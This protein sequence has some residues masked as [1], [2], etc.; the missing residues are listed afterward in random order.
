MQHGPHDLRISGRKG[1][2]RAVGAI[3]AGLALAACDSLLEVSLPGQTPAAALDD[4]AYASLLVLSAQGDFECAYAN[5]AFQ[6]GHLSG[7]L[8]GAQSSLNVTPIQ[9][10]TI[11]SIDGPWGESGCGSNFALYTPLSTARFMADDALRR[12][13]A[14]TDAEVPNRARLLGRASLYAGFS[15]GVFGESFCRATF[16]MGPEMAPREVLQLAAERFSAAIDFATQAGDDETLRAAYVGR[17]RVRLQ[18]GEGAA[19]AADARM[20]PAGFRFEV[21]RSNTHA[22][23]RNTIYVSNNQTRAHSVD[24]HFW[25]VTWQDTPDPR[26]RVTNTGQKGVDGL[27]DL[28]LQTKFTAEASPI[29]LASHT[30]AILIIAEVEGGETAVGII[31]EL[32]QAAGIPPFSSD[33]PGEILQM[34]REE[35][36]R[37]FFLEGRRMADLRRYGGNAFAEA[38]HGVHPFTG[39]I[40]GGTE[41]FPL[42][43]VELRNNPNVS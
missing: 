33:D 29:R 24:P 8:I 21:T 30:E 25:D 43:D 32:H 19:A 13:T 5:Y 6:A 36:R 1:R 37:E 26:V 18:L 3:L 39:Q 20:V 12:I 34:V 10:R 7:E 11:R 42:P 2:A 16:D 41:C 4:P 23:R 38:A 14:F 35:R 40:F 31:N 28:W 27:T 9:T 15:Y 22:R 17:A